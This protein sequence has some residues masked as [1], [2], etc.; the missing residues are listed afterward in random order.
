MLVCLVWQ[1]YAHLY[2]DT[3]QIT[4]YNKHYNKTILDSETEEI[5]I[6]WNILGIIR[7]PQWLGGKEPASQCRRCGFNP[8]DGKSP[9]RRKWQ[10]TQVYL[11]GK[12][13]GQRSLVGYS[14]NSYFFSE[15]FFSKN[16]YYFFRYLIE[17]TSK[18]LYIRY[19]CAKNLNY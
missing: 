5:L 16:L 14:Y 18:V 10:L 9:W 4:R 7:L 15:M 12:S 2:T 17:F 11:F 13:H 6:L 3:I 19:F 8:W 1:F